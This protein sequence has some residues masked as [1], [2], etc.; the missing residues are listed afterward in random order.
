VQPG[1]TSEMN[2]DHLLSLLAAKG[3][4]R[5]YAKRLAANDN[6]KNQIYFGSGFKA[7]NVIPYGAVVAEGGATRP[8]FKAAVD[9]W[10]VESASTVRPALGAQLILYPQYP[11]V[12]FS[13][14]L[15][16]VG[17]AF[18]KVMASRDP[19]RILVLGITQGN[20]VYGW[21]ACGDSAVAKELLERDHLGLLR[22]VGVFLELVTAEDRAGL[23]AEVSLL[24]ELGRIHRAGWIRAKRL[25]MDGTVVPCRGV[26]CGGSTLEAELG[27]PANSRA[28]PDYLGYEVKQHHVARFAKPSGGG[29]ITLMTPEPTGGLY[30]ERGVEEFVRTYGYRDKRGRPDRLNVGGNYRVGVR[31]DATHLTLVLAGWDETS[32]KILDDRGGVALVDDAG[33]VAAFWHFAGLISHWSRKHD[34]AVYVPSLC[35]TDPLR[36]RYGDLVRIGEGADFLLVIEA[37]S[38]GVVYY[39]PG[40]KLENATSAP[41]VKRRSQFRVKSADLGLLYESFRTVGV[42]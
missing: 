38:R 28:A 35:A 30:R 18:N 42:L 22:H 36:Y 7:L 29:A 13:G 6:S 19:G 16:G 32:G 37:M 21:A 12:R 1:S 10:W 4:R 33:T 14:F 40:I 27:V 9:F 2:L 5:F 17:G 20:R 3:C 39:D 11:E 41:R 8:R 26:N 25:R 24:M 34:R 23:Q 31:V 15:R